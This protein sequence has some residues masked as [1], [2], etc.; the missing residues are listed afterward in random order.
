MLSKPD[1]VL[2]DFGG[3]LVEESGYDLHAGN[4]WVLSRASVLPS[5]VTL[6]AV[7]ARAQYIAQRVLARRDDTQVE[8]PWSAVARLIYDHFGV[9]FDDPIS[10]LELGFWR[11]AVQTRPLL[12][13]VRDTLERLAS[14]GIRMAVIS[15]TMFTA[16]TLRAE[17]DSHG[18]AK[19]FEFILSS[20]ELSIR[21]PNPLLFELAATRLG[22]APSSIWFVGD[23]LDADVVGANAAGMT[24]VMLGTRV[25]SVP[26]NDKP[27][28][29]IAD[30]RA[31]PHWA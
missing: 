6:D 21:K 19:Y 30:W 8:T 29:S 17:L 7:V 2:F 20:A 25:P 9:Q 11:A 31:W 26:I 28:I 12:P 27:A 22:V 24:S 3:T 23:R 4:T 18:L 1:A 5:H 15:N 16:G 13:G 10:D 14:D